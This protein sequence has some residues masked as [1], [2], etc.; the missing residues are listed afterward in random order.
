MTVQRIVTLAFGGEQYQ[1][2]AENLAI[3]A[4][5]FGVGTVLVTSSDSKPNPSYYD[6]IIRTPC[7]GK[8][9]DIWGLKLDLHDIVE[10]SGLKGDFAFIDADALIVSDPSI[11]FSSLQN[12]FFFPVESVHPPEWTWAFARPMG[13]LAL[14]FC[15]HAGTIPQINGGHFLWTQDSLVARK[16]FA[17]AKAALT[18]LRSQ[19]LNREEPAMSLALCAVPETHAHWT[20]KTKICQLWCAAHAYTA[21]LQ[22]GFALARMPWW[23]RIERPVVIHHGSGYMWSERYMSMVRDLNA[24]ATLK[25]IPHVT[26]AVLTH[27]RVK[28]LQESL[29][30][31]LKQDY[32]RFSVLVI[33]DCPDQQLSIRDSRVTIINTPRYSCVGE[34]RNNAFALAREYLLFVDD[35]D[36][37]TPWHL[38]AHVSNI[39]RNNAVA[40]IS[41]RCLSFTRSEQCLGFGSAPIDVMFHK[42]VTARFPLTNTGEDQD[43]RAA[44]AKD[45]RIADMILPNPS[46]IYEWSNGTHHISGNPETARTGFDADVRARFA[47]GEEPRGAIELLP[48]L[49]PDIAH[50]WP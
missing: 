33:N 20:D 29:F 23:D 39:Q 25:N 42:K 22:H 32:P 18:F 4:Q 8:I 35:D 38:S 16:W 15:K 11:L 2:F 37:V 47:S 7:G 31:I 26:V 44:L 40:S 41:L 36:L 28:W 30:T 17:S 12:G 13:K 45:G 46:Y 3:S 24:A 34:K 1:R 21:S 27:G 6:T 19:G 49:Q 10:K 43:F 50:W 9:E 48:Q 5:R 14:E